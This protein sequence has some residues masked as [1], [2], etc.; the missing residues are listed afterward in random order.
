MVV[1]LGVEAMYAFMHSKPK[2]IPRPCTEPEYLVLPA[3][4]TIPNNNV[5]PTR[6]LP[7][8]T[9]SRY[10]IRPAM[11]VG[12]NGILDDVV[13]DMDDTGVYHPDAKKARALEKE[14]G[15][16]EDKE[17]VKKKKQRMMHQQRAQKNKEKGGP[18]TG[19]DHNI[20]VEKEDS[21]NM[22]ENKLSL[23]VI[24][25][26]SSDPGKAI[27]KI[28]GA[29]GN[30]W[31]V[32]KFSPPAEIA[33]ENIITAGGRKRKAALVRF[34]SESDDQGDYESD[35]EVDYE[36]DDDHDEDWKAPGKRVGR[37][38]LTKTGACEDCP[39]KDGQKLY[40][41]CQ[42]PEHGFMI[43]CEGPCNNWYHGSC[44]GI[45]ARMA[46]KMVE[47][48]C[49]TPQLALMLLLLIRN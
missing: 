26:L 40:C 5:G 29:E 14:M 25:K 43:L 24:L 7:P 37:H 11:A 47:Y 12:P 48:I 30:Q 36:S 13:Y 28:I 33:L 35:N 32:F 49:I 27:L 20:A 21:D 45:T 18:S 39:S 34:G 17:A 22:L 38:R 31:P 8:R 1:V 10:D 19:E 23:H 4:Y 42:Q 44:V 41:I 3:V 15:V 46:E 2:Y 16:H 9:N 6:E